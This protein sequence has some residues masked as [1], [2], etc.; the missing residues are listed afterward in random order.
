[1]LLSK[2]ENS[3]FEDDY[4]QGKGNNE[5]ILESEEWWK[6]LLFLLISEIRR[7]ILRFGPV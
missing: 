3:R 4:H 5:C 1:M 2:M 7:C 6:K